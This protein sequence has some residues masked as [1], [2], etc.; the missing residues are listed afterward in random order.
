[1]ST[2]YNIPHLPLPYDIESSAVLKQLNA[3]NRALAELKGIANTIPNENIL[4]ST[5]S[6]QEAKES[7]EIEN[8]VTTQDDIYKAELHIQPVIDP[9]TKEVLNYREAILYGF[10]LVKTDNLLTINI[11]QKIQSILECNK[12]GFRKLPGTTLSRNDGTIVYTPPQDID[13]ITNLMS[14]LEFFINDPNLCSLD[15]LIKLAI[16]H[17]Q[18]ESIH[19][20][21]DGNGRTGRI[22]NVLYLVTQGLLDFP[23]LYLSRYITQ[24]KVEYY[25]L[26][27]EIRENNGNNFHQW[28]EWILFMLRAIEKTSLDTIS[29]VK[30]IYSLMQ[31][32]KQILRHLFGIQYK[33]ELLNNLFFHPYTKI[34]FL[35]KDMMI[36]RQTASKMLTLMAD[37]GLLRKA[38]VGRQNYY[39]NSE[40]VELFLNRP[41]FSEPQSD[42][43]QEQ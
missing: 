11:I 7:S 14:N 13:S 23:I 39:I 18:F 5:L 10:K 8:I 12:A 28:E 43:R 6:L 9:V 20:F 41:E 3:A 1:M 36:S 15:P 26:I 25:H 42:N 34:D 33:H 17:H 37:K 29:L 30:G 21:Y 22:I 32:Y 27:Q 19:P 35:S 2:S 40:L 31:K 24:N 38:K 4:I 16:I